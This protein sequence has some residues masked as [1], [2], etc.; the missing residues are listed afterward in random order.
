MRPPVA[1]RPEVLA[2]WADS[3]VKAKETCRVW[4]P[5][6]P[7]GPEPNCE[8]TGT[9]AVS[10]SRVKEVPLLAW[11]AQVAWEVGPRIVRPMER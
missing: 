11:V 9:W 8:A 2:G 7:V 5:P 4:V 1:E 10:Q 3:V 6:G